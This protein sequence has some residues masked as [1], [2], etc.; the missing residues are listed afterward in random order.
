MFL[1]KLTFEK[2]NSKIEEGNRLP[3]LSAS[4]YK[5]GVY[6]SFDEFKGNAP[7]LTDYEFKAGKLGDVLYVKKDSSEYPDRTAWGFCDGKNI[8]INSADKF[9]QLIQS[10]NTFYF[11]GIK[12]ITKTLRV[13]LMY[14]SVLNLLDNTVRKKSHFNANPKY[15]QIDM[16]TGDIY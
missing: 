4:Q 10:G 7:S 1:P 16:E 14:A 13:E 3:I 11:K 6:A 9:S 8:Y 12:S 5:K 2:I 15:Y